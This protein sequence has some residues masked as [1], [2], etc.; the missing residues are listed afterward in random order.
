MCCISAQASGTLVVADLSNLLPMAASSSTMEAAAK[1]SVPRPP[2]P[3][4][5][6]PPAS[7]Q[8]AWRRISRPPKSPSYPPPASLL[9]AAEGRAKSK[10]M[11]L[12]AV[13]QYR[14]PATAAD[15]PCS[16]PK[17]MPSERM[18][19]VKGAPPKP[20][21][22]APPPKLGHCSLLLER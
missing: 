8:V 18:L 12:V 21:K 19:T 4:S 5:H 14:K 16:G 6:P 20:R 15:M 2:K 17:K 10:A 1:W 3:P 11:G 22:V 7:L 13:G 9:A